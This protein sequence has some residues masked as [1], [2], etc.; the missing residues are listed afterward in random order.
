MRSIPK[1]APEKSRGWPSPAV[2]RA[3]LPSACVKPRVVAHWL[4]GGPDEGG[5][6]RWLAGRIGG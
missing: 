3:A 2:L 1:A 5:M 4:E 6:L